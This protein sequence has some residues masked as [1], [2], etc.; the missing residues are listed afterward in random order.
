MPAPIKTASATA[1]KKDNGEKYF[2]ALA[3]ALEQKR[4]APPMAIIKAKPLA[5]PVVIG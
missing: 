5:K 4:S 1:Q 3:P 2:G